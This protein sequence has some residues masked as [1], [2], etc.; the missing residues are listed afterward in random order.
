MQR[1]RCAHLVFALAASG[2][3]GVAHAQVA[4]NAAQADYSGI[5]DQFHT[6]ANAWGP[7]LQQ[8]ATVLYWSLITI[9]LVLTFMPMALRGAE[10][11]EWAE[12]LFRF[13][14]VTGFW[15]WMIHNFSTLA[16][17]II[18]GFWHAGQNAA[19]A[20]GGNTRL[21]P[22]DVVSTGLNI[23]A[24]VAQQAHL[25]NPGTAIVIGLA[26]LVILVVFA[27]M[28]GVIAITLV[29]TFII[30]NAAVIF[31]A[32]AGFQFSAEIARHA[33]RYVIGIGAKLFALQLIIGVASAIFQNWS[34]QFNA[35]GAVATIPDALSLVALVVLV[36]YLANSVPS[37]L[38]GIVT[39]AHGTGQSIGSM[40][41]A[42]TTAMAVGANTAMTVGGGALKGAGGTINAAHGGAKLASEQLR[43]ATLN[44]TAPTSKLE[45]FGA[46]TGAT[47]ANVAW[48]AA[49]DIG[50]RLGGRPNYG[51]GS[52]GGRMGDSMRSQAAEKSAARERP[53]SPSST[54]TGTDG[55][56]IRGATS[57][58]NSN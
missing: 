44:G 26:A 9:S 42:G 35:A 32:L 22:W 54:A 58:G 3:M 21:D 38:M 1:F 50:A 48:A 37:A 45:R 36:F 8:A 10:L 46:A 14:L 41:A 34:T 20:S 5:I 18:K 7:A 39:G 6:A 52:I 47:A 23:S 25:W 57:D 40:V 24:A 2:A 53:S 33:I 51:S 13:V 16:D 55:G 43:D 29:E 31:M 15:L 17:D 4:A 12:T 56:T 28:A 49:K 11:N 27:L 30:I 19:A